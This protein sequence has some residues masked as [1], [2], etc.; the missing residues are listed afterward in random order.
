MKKVFVMLMAVCA[1]S[2]STVVSAQE[3]KLE[4]KRLDRKEMKERQV[5]MM[6]QELNLS[7]EQ[8]MQIKAAK[9][10]LD[11]SR[12]GSRENMKTA[13]DKYRATV[14]KV[15]TP[16]QK[17]KF[18]EM[19]KNHHGKKEFRAQARE[20][21]KGA[22]KR[23]KCDSVCGKHHKGHGQKGEC[24]GE[25]KCDSKHKK[26]CKGECPQVKDCD[27]KQ[28]CKGDCKDGKAC[29]KKNRECAKSKDCNKDCNKK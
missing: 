19:K 24:P 10:E 8:L 23:M 7:D 25:M 29:E 9:E 21:K 17:V 12:Q 18:E 3:Q 5:S 22:H 26:D 1:M 14:D 16:E 2:M 15:L 13:H 28:D 4:A 6:K 20:I 27:K 11:A